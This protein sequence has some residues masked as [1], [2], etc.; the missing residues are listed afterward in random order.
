MSV[1]ELIVGSLL[2][3]V[4]LSAWGQE[5]SSRQKALEAQRKKLTEEIKQINTLL[6]SSKKKEKDALTE[7]EDLDVK[8]D[9][10]KRLIRVTNAEVN[11]LDKRINV[12]TRDIQNLRD[13]L[14][15]L[16][17]DY[18]KMIR[19]SY[20]SKSS[21]NRLMFLFSS[22]S[23]L[24]AYKRLQYLKQYAAFR[25]KQGEEIAEK[26][27]TLQELNQTLIVQKEKKETLI[28]ENRTVQKALAK[29]LDQQQRLV[30]SLR[31]KG[32]KYNRQIAQKQ[33]QAEK[34]D[35]EINRLIREAIA[36]SNKKAGKKGETTFALTPEDRLLAA[37][38]KG[39]KGRLP[40]PVTRGVVVQRFGTQPHPVVRTTMI[41]SN[42]ITIATAPKTQARAVFEGEVMSLMSFRGSNPTVLVKHGN[43][44]TAYKNLAKVYVKK[45]Q[46]VAAK[47]ALGEVFSNPQTGKT[48]L[49]FSIFNN[50]KPQNPSQ[51]LTKM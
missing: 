1:K 39:N 28:E 6:F 48:N 51:W 8:M 24:Q 17:G 21:Q 45:G 14:K 34:I 13:E 23:L 3:A 4:S 15:T 19:Q 47:Q 9:V 2:F 31:K 43:Y 46:K 40:W 26:T 33:K 41:K 16:K 10:R 50:T 36:A 38:F 37:N 44:I 7:V 11:L 32:R 25:K 27:R 18:A 12:N 30:Q 35:K 20:K 22:S 42:G 5:P 29:E 49:Q